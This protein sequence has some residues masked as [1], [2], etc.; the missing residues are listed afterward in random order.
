MVF[1][2]RNIRDDNTAAAIPSRRHVRV[3]SGRYGG[4]VRAHK[5]SIFE[6]TGTRDKADAAVE[7]K[8]KAFD[9]K[10]SEI[11][12]DSEENRR[13]AN[14]GTF[15]L[16]IKIIAPQNDQDSKKPALSDWQTAKVQLR[17]RI[18]R[19]LQLHSEQQ[20]PPTQPIEKGRRQIQQQK[21]PPQTQPDSEGQQK[22]SQLKLEG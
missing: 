9:G 5:F 21:Q 15:E 3:V 1:G 7:A 16:G 10:N 6:G 14:I 4:S 17:Q 22:K 12:L 19:L 11:E 20:P 13:V 8:A 2:M 18:R